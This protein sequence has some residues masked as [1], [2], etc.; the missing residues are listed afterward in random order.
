MGPKTSG[1]TPELYEY[2]LSVSLR[3]PDILREL[4][5]YSATRP[6]AQMLIP[7]DQGQFLNLLLKIMGAK[8]VLEVGTFTGYSTLWMALAL[9]EDGHIT[10]CDIDAKSGAIAQD[11]WQKAGLDHKITLHLAPA[12]ETLEDL[13][14][15]GCAE[16]FDFAFIDADKRNYENYYEKCLQLVRCGGVL[17]IDNILWSGRIIN[18]K[19]EDERTQALRRL[20]GRL[21][22][23]NRVDLSLLAV[24]DG[25]TLLCKK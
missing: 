7:P 6:G 11:F 25:L 10:A 12:L 4:R 24:G 1:T 16:T 8:N 22:S 2:L 20:N 15:Q 23:D 9:P 13:L 3:E 19:S 18:P 5:E 17:A 14:E 21:L